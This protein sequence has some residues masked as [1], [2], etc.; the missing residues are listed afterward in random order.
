MILSEIELEPSS[1]LATKI[2][3]ACDNPSPPPQIQSFIQTH[4]NSPFPTH[5]DQSF[6]STP[7]TF[8]ASNSVIADGSSSSAPRPSP[9][10]PPRE[11]SPFFSCGPAT[12]PHANVSMDLIIFD[13][14]NILD[15][16]RPSPVA[17]PFPDL[18]APTP[19]KRPALSS[20]L[21]GINSTS[22]STL[23]DTRTRSLYEQL[24]EGQEQNNT[25]SI[26]VIP[27]SNPPALESPT[28]LRHSPCA[29]NTGFPAINPVQGNSI[30]LHEAGALDTHL[31]QP[32]APSSR[33]NTADIVAEETWSPSRPETL[34]P[35]SDGVLN[36]LLT[37]PET[38]TTPPLHQ[39][40][41]LTSVFPTNQP[42][43]DRPCTP[44]RQSSPVQQSSPV[45]IHNVQRPPPERSPWRSYIASTGSPTKFA[46]KHTLHDPD[47]T[48]ARRIPIKEAIAQGS[49]SPKKDSSFGPS[50]GLFGRPVFTRYIRTPTRRS[51]SD[52][53]N[54]AM[55]ASPKRVRSG[56]EEPQVSRR[57]PHFSRPFLRSASDSEIFSPSKPRGIPTF[58][59]VPSGDGGP[60]CT[61]PEEPALNSPMKLVHLSPQLRSESRQPSSVAGSRI[62]RIGVK[63]YARPHKERQQAKG[64]EPGHKLLFMTRRSTS[65]SAPTKPV[66][67]VKSVNVAGSG[68]SFEDLAVPGSGTV[69]SGVLSNS[70]THITTAQLSPSLK[71]KRSPEEISS[72]ITAHPAF[73]RRVASV[74]KPQQ[75]T[76]PVPPI[77]PIESGEL[78]KK[79]RVSHVRKVGGDTTSRKCA[80]RSPDTQASAD[81]AGR[82]GET[83]P[84]SPSL[85]SQPPPLSLT[86]S[87]AFQ[88]APGSTSPDVPADP[89]TPPEIPPIPFEFNGSSSNKGSSSNTTRATRSRRV[90]QPPSDIFGVV[91]PLPQHRWRPTETPTEGTFPS[92]SAVALKALTTSN[93][94][95][96]QQNLVAILET[97][98]I[99]KPGNR[100]G[101]PTT[102]AKT[103]D[104]KR[105][106]EQDKGRKERAERRARRASSPLDDSSLTSE[107]ENLSLGP[108]HRLLRHR[109]GPG[110]EEEYESPERAGQSA[111]RAHT[112]EAGEPGKKVEVKTVRWDHG[113]FTTVYFD[114]LPL[115]SRTCDK[116][117][118]PVA[119]SRGAL[120]RSAKALRLDSLGNVVN[121]TSPMKDLVQENV[122]IKKFVYDDDAEA[123]KFD[124]PKSSS[125]GKGKKSKG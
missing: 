86:L 112:C 62:P 85:G 55:V 70:Q 36:D 64:K 14:G 11:R 123:A 114:G 52:A 45:A 20:F 41:V 97:E 54:D 46:F 32:D 5:S 118:I 34:S 37:T 89:A 95:R 6:L 22:Q 61:I 71:R 57:P 26:R 18:L 82:T 74:S 117:Q 77:P 96:N 43:H 105:K 99:R 75:T 122:I 39:I 110:D 31:P 48:P 94:A 49:A 56:S 120:A 73:A 10:P 35:V 50:T 65:G 111:K 7:A 115:Q 103:I 79:A 91:R 107:D 66:R 106:L 101:S 88:S 84:I 76:S 2:S 72:P 30:S 68:S 33:K 124:V 104:E 12:F 16:P 78:V 113:L 63:L 81:E 116:P 108:N 119:C 47:R 92:M 121:V 83:C 60:P 23:S 38:I 3:R 27:A 67:L 93:T 87:P 29:S 25:T 15:I 98:V 4:D 102:R 58:S 9:P 53:A 8:Q 90:P 13:D 42:P 21:G 51:P 40:P 17:G 80:T 125:K 109:R 59:I 44:E 19:L 100:P 24:N 28:Q 69:N 1:A